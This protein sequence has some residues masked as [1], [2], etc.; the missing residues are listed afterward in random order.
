MSMSLHAK[1]LY[2]LIYNNI[3]QKY[4]RIRYIFYIFIYEEHIK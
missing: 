1:A 3:N 4:N 2:S